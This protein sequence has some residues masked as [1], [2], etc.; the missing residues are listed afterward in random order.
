V[1]SKA[2]ASRS[3]GAHLASLASLASLALKYRLS[4]L[5]L[6]N[7]Q[8]CWS[9]LVR[10]CHV[11]SRVSIL[12]VGVFVIAFESFTYFVIQ[13]PSLSDTDQNESGIRY[14]IVLRPVFPKKSN[15]T[16]RDNH[17]PVHLC[18]FPSRKL[19]DV[20]LSY[21]EDILLPHRQSISLLNMGT[22]KFT[23]QAYPSH[24]FLLPPSQIFDQLGT[25]HEK[26][27]SQLKV[28]EAQKIYGPNKIEGESGVKWYSVLLKQISNAMI[29]V[30][31]PQV[32]MMAKHAQCTANWSCIPEE[33]HRSCSQIEKDS[34]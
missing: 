30:R 25:N 23:K 6:T 12:S 11:V 7:S 18:S 32:K 24:P 27:L 29:L 28:Q 8:C 15:P 20:F 26:G 16:A 34:C 2:V 22:S 5:D 1:G 33:G 9:F 17:D 31:T 10:L 3:G 21:S 14:K 13:P 19:D 4:A